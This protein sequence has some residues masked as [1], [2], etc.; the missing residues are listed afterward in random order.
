MAKKSL[1]CTL[2]TPTAQVVSG[3]V[4]YAAIPAWDGSL[5]V[6]PG[7]APL[8]AKL[9][10]GELRL[11]F[12]DTDKGKGGSTSYY[13]EGGFVKVA[14]DK[15]TILAERA[16]PLEDLDASKA[17]AELKDA[18]NATVSGQG[19]MLRVATDARTEARH[20]ARTKVRLAK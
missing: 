14:D 6:Q 15:L 19:D 1:D 17:E 18:Q 13:I 16:I 5:G 10:V 20:R 8:L 4:V 2:V 3:K 7:R 12:A 11:D 9:G